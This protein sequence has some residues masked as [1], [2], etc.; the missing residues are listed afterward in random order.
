MKEMSP[1]ENSLRSWIPRRPS[2]RVRTRLFGRPSLAPVPVTRPRV[3]WPWLAPATAALFMSVML[4]SQSRYG[5]TTLTAT[6]SGP[7]VTATLLATPHVA[8]A[9]YA[10]LPR[11]D[12]NAWS[13]ATFEWTNR[14]QSLTTPPG[15]LENQA[16]VPATP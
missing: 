16:F 4:V 9:L 3:V 5:L 13:K 11:S 14:S 8:S 15:N 2:E 7:D 6:A 1:I 12:R 10:E